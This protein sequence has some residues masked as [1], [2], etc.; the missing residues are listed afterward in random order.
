V[1]QPLQAEGVPVGLAQVEQAVL[2]SGWAKLRETLFARYDL[3][4]TAIQLQGGWLIGQLLAQNQSLLE[5]L[6]CGLE[7]TP[8]QRLAVQLRP[9]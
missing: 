4:G 7:A 1:R 6:E 2:Q 5:R 3:S 8:E 9:R